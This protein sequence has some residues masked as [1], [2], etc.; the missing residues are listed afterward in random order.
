MGGIDFVQVSIFPDAGQP[1][2]LSLL[3][4]FQRRLRGWEVLGW[5][6]VDQAPLQ[7]ASWAGWAWVREKLG[8]GG[9]GEG[10][11][12]PGPVTMVVGAGLWPRPWVLTS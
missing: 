10:A 8:G 6:S 7:A 5:G 11:A 1:E 12:W 2:E 3:V 9:E 4:L